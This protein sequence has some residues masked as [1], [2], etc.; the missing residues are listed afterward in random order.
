MRLKAIKKITRA[1]KNCDKYHNLMKPILLQK[2]MNKERLQENYYNTDLTS[3][4]VGYVQ[5]ERFNCVFAF[6]N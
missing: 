5:K 3:I 4:P 1:I 6:L 2:I